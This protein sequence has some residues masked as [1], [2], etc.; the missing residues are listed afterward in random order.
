MGSP[1][2]GERAA[3]RRQ[4]IFYAPSYGEMPGGFQGSVVVFTA[5]GLV[6]GVSNNVNYDVK[7][8]GSAAYN[9]PVAATTL[10]H[11]Q[12]DLGPIQRMTDVA[13]GTLT[14]NLPV[15][16]SVPVLLEI[17]ETRLLQ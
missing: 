8:D 15:P 4:F 11:F 9:M 7:F 10:L 17:I 14:V 5:A 13:D 1:G 2:R 3:R 12:S 6:V 16:F